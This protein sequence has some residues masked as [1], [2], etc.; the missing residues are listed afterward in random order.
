MQDEINYQKLR[1]KK[2]MY[3]IHLLTNKGYPVTTVFDNEVKPIPT[4]R[5][6]EFLI[7]RDKELQLEE[8]LNA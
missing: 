8:E 7:Q 3:L 4:L 5:F 6:E 1:E 2:F